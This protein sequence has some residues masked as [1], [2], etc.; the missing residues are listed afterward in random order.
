MAMYLK[1]YGE[2]NS[3]SPVPRTVKVK[4]KKEN[5]NRKIL[6]DDQSEQKI[7]SN[8]YIANTKC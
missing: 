7:F 2:T 6:T 5:E 8:R 1:L 3:L 4:L